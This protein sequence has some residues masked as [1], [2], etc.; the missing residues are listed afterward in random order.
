[1]EFGIEGTWKGSLVERDAGGAK[2]EGRHSVR[3]ATPAAVASS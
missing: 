1:V 2:N 3:A